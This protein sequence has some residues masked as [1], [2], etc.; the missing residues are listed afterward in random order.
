MKDLNT[1]TIIGNLTRDAELKYTTS[2]TALC[3][4]GI[5]NKRS[6]KKG[7]SWEDVAQ[8][9]DITL[10]A[11][12]AENLHKYLS[13][14]TKVCIEGE[15]IQESYEK[16]GQK[17]QKIKIHCN[18]IHLLGGGSKVDKKPEVVNYDKAASGNNEFDHSAFE[19]E[20]P[21]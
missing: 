6:I 3:S 9:F 12:K 5:A 2:G 19:E 20:I 15:L 18:E 8:F 16:D 1:L 10:W 7:D 4:F 17:I 13:K 21:F 14:G 11:K